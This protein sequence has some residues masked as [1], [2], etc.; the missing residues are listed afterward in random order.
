MA[1]AKTNTKRRP[2]FDVFV[3]DGDDEGKAK[4]FWTKV[5][6]AWTHEDGDGLAIVLAALPVNG[7]LVLR[8]PK[9]TTETP[10]DA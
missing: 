5:G 7:R 4:G 6:G 8:K 9:P 3:V 1:K 10:P 2:D